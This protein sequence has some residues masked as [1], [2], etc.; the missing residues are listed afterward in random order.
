MI[1]FPSTVDEKLPSKKEF[2][3]QKQKV[4]SIPSIST[5]SD[6]LLVLSEV[7]TQLDITKAIGTVETESSKNLC[8]Y[9]VLLLLWNAI[10]ISLR[11]SDDFSQKSGFLKQHATFGITKSVI[12]PFTSNKIARMLFPLELLKKL[13]LKFIIIGR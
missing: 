2:G 10:I 6:D 9:I 5:N 3:F 7:T 1:P 11:R 13:T 4:H 8:R 12:L